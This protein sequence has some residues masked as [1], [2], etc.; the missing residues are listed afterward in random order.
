MSFKNLQQKNI[1]F[2]LLIQ[3]H[4][5]LFAWFLPKQMIPS[6]AFG[7]NLLYKPEHITGADIYS[8]GYFHQPLL[9]DIPAGAFLFFIF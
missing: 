4:F 8:A 1:F 9:D 3:R 5:L 6:L 7:S 2:H